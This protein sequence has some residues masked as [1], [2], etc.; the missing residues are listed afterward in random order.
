M[1]ELL[2]APFLRKLK[3]SL[4]YSFGK[5]SLADLLTESL[6][7]SPLLGRLNYSTI[8]WNFFVDMW[9]KDTPS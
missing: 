5:E 3:F 1:P 2:Q 8:I 7:S 9:E 4:F 6:L